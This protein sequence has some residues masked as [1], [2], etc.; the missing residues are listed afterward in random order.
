MNIINKWLRP[1]WQHSDASVRLKALT[2][3]VVDLDTCHALAVSDPD[4]AVREQAVSKLESV[5]HLLDVLRVQPTTQEFVAARLTTL[6]QHAPAAKIGP[7]LSQTL[8]VIGTTTGLARLASEAS[9]TEIRVAAVAIMSDLVTLQRCAL[10]DR[11]IDVRV[12]AVERI[13]DEDAL[14]KI[15]RAAKSHDKTVARI[16]V[17]RLSFL[18][19]RRK[20]IA[21]LTQLLDELHCLVDASELDAD[22]LHNARRRW[23]RLEGEA[24]P[25]QLERFAAMAPRLDAR[26]AALQKARKEDL[27]HKVERERLIA[28]LRQLAVKLP[29]AD[30]QEARATLT[31][32]CA[33]WEQAIPLQDRWT[34][35]RLLEEWQEAAKQLESDLREREKVAYHEQTIAAAISEIEGT[36]EH[37]A[38]HARQI[39]TARQR[40]SELSRKHADNPAFEKSLQ[41]LHNLVDRMA[42]KLAQEQNDLK[43]VQHKLKHA[44]EALETALAQKQLDQA[45][46][47]HKTVSSLLTKGVDCPEFK[48]IRRR[49]AK[50]EPLLR[51]LQSWRN[52]SSDHAREELVDEARQLVDAKIDIDERVRVL[53]NLRAR[54]KA[55]GGGGPKTR[56]LWETFDAACSA[57][58][59]PVK[60]DRKDQALQREQ[61]LEVRSGLCADLERLASDTDWSAPN[62]RAVDRGLSEAKRQWRTAGAIPRN[63]WNALRE[64]FD[65]A[66][67][68]VEQHLS[69]ERRHNF[70]QRQ[71]LVKEAQALANHEDIRQA[72]AEARRLRE[73]WQVTAHSARKDEQALWKTFNAALDDVF[74][75]DR[76]ARNEFK[77][78]LKEQRQQAETL[79]AELE[80]L[81]RA[82][83][84][85]IHA[86]RAELSRLSA[87]FGQLGALPREA[88]RDLENRFRKAGDK[89]QERIA[90]AELAHAQQALLD[91]QSLHDICEQAEAMVQNT[92]PDK[93]TTAML[94]ATWQARPKPRAHKDLMEALERR[95]ANA[96]ATMA[97]S[98]PAPDK[99]TLDR[100]AA[101]RSEICLDLEILR[102]Q[103]S[104][105]DCHHERMQRQVALLEEAMKG[106]DEPQ[107]RHMRRLQ[108]DYLRQGPVAGNMQQVFAERFGRLFP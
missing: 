88:R 100:N 80:G 17:Q 83:E 47:A 50:C 1:K 26:L 108:I 46:K 104:P 40:C 35:R 74:N 102:K 60:Q 67:A 42:R 7:H 41:R 18:R 63:K 29:S 95:F 81:T 24:E 51:E 53:K 45:M 106:A 37:G 85:D 5:E 27:S 62:W 72:V 70:L 77:A 49:L 64:R 103:E 105:P 39:E 33:D 2:E 56:R 69:K 31:D 4:P 43:T 79:C 14:Q 16:A 91:Y 99:Q 97:G 20:R 36:L 48:P 54:W 19:T 9:D 55:L 21:E 59:E 6:L 71:A 34:G 12:R 94:E 87:A 82:A 107:E 23:N 10:E 38:L 65:R 76:A 73:G 3:Q 11:A 90:V 61:H 32:L 78:G 93:E 68:G 89:L 86:M 57:A 101:V 28:Q 84:L 22:V 66:V 52:W 8:A 30:P 44:I 96:I 92:L 98:E 58:H 75:R 13:D 25:A 15:G